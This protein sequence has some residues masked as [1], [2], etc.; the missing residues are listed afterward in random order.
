MRRITPIQEKDCPEC[1]KPMRW[2]CLDQ[3][4]CESCNPMNGVPVKNHDVR[5][6]DQIIKRLSILRDGIEKGLIHVHK[7]GLTLSEQTETIES[8]CIDGQVHQVPCK[9]TWRVSGDLVLC[10]QEKGNTDETH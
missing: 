3:P 7:G 5:Q 6:L 1:G 10:N 9:R 2:K 4:R 8:D